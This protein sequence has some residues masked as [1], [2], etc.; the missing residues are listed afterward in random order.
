M[1][2]AE[3]PAV[4]E[5]TLHASWHIVAVF[6]AW[7]GVVFWRGGVAARDFAGLWIASAIVF[8]AVDLWQAGLAGLVMNPQWTLLGVVGCIAWFGSEKK[9]V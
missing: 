7:S 8:I 6:L 9:N 2:A 3:L 5:G 4:A 1:L